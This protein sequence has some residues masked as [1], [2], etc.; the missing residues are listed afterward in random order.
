MFFGFVFDYWNYK[1]RI[2]FE[3]KCIHESYNETLH[4][5]LLFAQYREGSDYDDFSTKQYNINSTKL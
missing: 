3:R 1:K 2:I 4:Y 5:D